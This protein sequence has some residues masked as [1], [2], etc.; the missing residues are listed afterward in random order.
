MY[1]IGGL[2]RNIVKEVTSIDPVLGNCEKL[3]GLGDAWENPTYGHSA[4]LY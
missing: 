2:S 3:K 4:S 1:L